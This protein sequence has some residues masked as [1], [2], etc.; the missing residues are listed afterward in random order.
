MNLYVVFHDNEY[1]LIAGDDMLDAIE[2][3][4]HNISCNVTSAQFLRKL[5]S[6]ERVFNLSK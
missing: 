3:C 6:S 4:F 1:V 5:E 2:F